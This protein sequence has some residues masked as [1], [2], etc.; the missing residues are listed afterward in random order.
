[1]ELKD[2]AVN[3]ISQ[4]DKLVYSDANIGSRCTQRKSGKEN[5]PKGNECL[6][7]MNDDRKKTDIRYRKYKRKY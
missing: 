2:H 4:T 7:E 5:E 6:T 3:K 1:L